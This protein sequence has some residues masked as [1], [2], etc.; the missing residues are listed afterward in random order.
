MTPDFWHGKRVFVSGHTGF[1]GGW[2]CLWLQSLGAKVTGFSLPP[3][4]ETNFFELAQVANGMN[5]IFGD[6]R[7]VAHLK[8]AMCEAKPEVTIHM[9]AQALVRKSYVD[10]IETYSTNVMGTVNFLEAVRACS[11]VKV[12]VNVTTD[13][14]YDNQEW[15]WPYRETDHLGGYDPYSS[16]KA[17]SELVTAAYRASFFHARNEQGVRVAIGSARAG[18]VIGGGDWSHDRLIPDVLH[19]FSR[20]E[21]VK[22]RNPS[23]IRPW[24]HVFEAL[25]GYLTLAECL[26]E[27]GAEF[28]GAF[29]FGPHSKDHRSV[30]WVVNELVNL[31]DGGASWVRDD[32]SYAHEAEVLKLDISKSQN[33]LGWK[34][35]LELR[36]ALGLTVL[37]HRA[38]AEAKNMK[39]FSLEQIA[40]YQQRCI[41]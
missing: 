11:S 12:V 5:S 19:A 6:V 13:K 41:P 40:H 39:D 37:W 31:W 28:G 16:S 2:L 14:C 10:P 22:I 17:C 3:S 7:D 8:D 35:Q 33:L 23:A 30:G 20:G 18:N 21:P 15:V 34:P 32:G 24:Q 36:D 27:R 9:A 1:K 38:L 26:L 25:C 29:N 4:G